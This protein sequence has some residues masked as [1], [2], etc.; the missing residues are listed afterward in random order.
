[1][2]RENILLTPYT[3]A[4]PT[5][6][7]HWMLTKCCFTHNTSTIHH[8]HLFALSSITYLEVAHPLQNEQ[9]HSSL[10]DATSIVT[11]TKLY[12]LPC[13][14]QEMLKYDLT[15]ECISFCSILMLFPIHWSNLYSFLFD[16]CDN[17]KVISNCECAASSCF[18]VCKLC[19]PFL[20]LHL[21]VSV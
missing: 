18:P 15:E 12:L 21:F 9:W 8:N 7:D 11:F 19:I 5:C 4:W 10:C 3:F 20:L 6:E 2:N 1:M 14:Y 16:A 17:F 13:Y